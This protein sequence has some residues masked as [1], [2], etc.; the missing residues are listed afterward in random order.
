MGAMSAVAIRAGDG[1]ARRE[2][3]GPVLG[4]V[5]CHEARVE[6]LRADQFVVA[7]KGGREAFAGLAGAGPARGRRTVDRGARTGGGNAVRVHA[8]REGCVLRPHAAVDDAD[9]HV[10]ALEAAA[11][12]GAGPH[13]AGGGQ[14]EEGR[15]GDGFQLAHLV[16]V[17]GHH[18]RVAHQCPHFGRRQARCEAVEHGLVA[19]D[20]RRIAH[21]RSHA[22]L[23]CV[24]VTRVG[25]RGR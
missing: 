2:E 17:Y 19:G 16:R 12:H 24:K 11:A 3:L 6:E 1:I 21:Q 9:D 15:S 14:P 22:D 7:V 18:F 25:Q 13:A 8:V 20:D 23:L 5:A 10:L 4:I